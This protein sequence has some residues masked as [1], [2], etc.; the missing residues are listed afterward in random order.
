LG[1]AFEIALVFAFISIYFKFDRE[2][3]YDLEEMKL[4]APPFVKKLV[5]LGP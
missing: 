1:V 3:L 4:F 5:R 2:R